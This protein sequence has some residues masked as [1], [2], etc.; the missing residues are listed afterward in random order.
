[1]ENHKAMM[2]VLIGTPTRST[3]EVPYLSG[4]MSTAA[5]SLLGNVIKVVPKII[6]TPYVQV[7]RTKIV[8]AA[9]ESDCSDVLFIDSDISQWGWPHVERI[10]S[11]DAD[12]V[13]GIYPKHKEGEPEWLL[14]C[15]RGATPDANG[16]ME[17]NDIATGFLR[18]RMRVFDEL[19][20][21]HPELDFQNEGDP[22]QYHDYFPMGVVNHKWRGEDLLF[23]H[24]A[25]A[26]GFRVFADT[27]IILKHRGTFDFPSDEHLSEFVSP[28]L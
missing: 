14:H 6:V 20:R 27:R 23:C 13:G 19:R 15:D 18:V 7:G 21:R 26:A 17:V 4:M 25:K 5:L 3:V 16:L 24:R 12:V 1:M 28:I 10:L 11:H 22:R 9:R 2:R 8:E